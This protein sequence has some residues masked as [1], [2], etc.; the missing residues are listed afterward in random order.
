MVLL[1]LLLGA[2]YAF[3]LYYRNKQNPRSGM[4]GFNVV[5]SGLRF[6]SASLLA[7]LLLNPLLR[8]VRRDIQK[9]EILIA[10][11]NSRSMLMN[12]D[13]NEVRNEVQRIADELEAELG[14]DYRIVRAGFDE[15][16]HTE[17]QYL[18]DFD[19][20]RTNV[21]QVI[22]QKDR[23]MTGSGARAVVLLS[24][25]IY[26]TGSYPA[27]AAAQSRI[28]I[29]TI[30]FGD[31][32]VYR[33]VRIAAVRINSL[34]FLGNEFPIEVDVAADRAG[35]GQSS[36]SVYKGGERLFTENITID[37]SRYTRTFRFMV[38]AD[39]IGAASYQVQV[40]KLNGERNL[41]NNSAYIS[42]EVID[43][44]QKILVNA[45]APHP[46]IAALREALES[47]DQYE[48]RFAMADLKSLQASDYDMVITHQMPANAA[49][50]E[51]LKGLTER[52]IPFLAVLGNATRIELFNR[53]DVG[54]RIDGN[55]ANFNQ[56]VPVLNANFDLFETEQNVRDLL[57]KV[58]PL[59]A[60]FGDYTV[61]TRDFVLLYQQVGSVRTELPMLS[62]SR[63]ESYKFGV[64]FGEGIWRWRLFDYE[65]H[66]STDKFRAFFGKVSQFLAIKD[67][68]RK[69]RVTP[70]ANSLFENEAISFRAELYNDN[71]EPVNTSNVELRILNEAGKEFTYN[72]Q[73]V[74]KFYSL[75][76]GNFGAGTYRY[77]ASTVLAGR[78]EQLGGTFVV[79]PLILEELNLTANHDVL[80][81]IAKNSN[82]IY[83]EGRAIEPIIESLKQEEAATGIVYSSVSFRDVIDLKW[84][85]FLLFG[86]VALE[87]IARRWAGSY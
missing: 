57:A 36:V 50:L 30:P 32:T 77:T 15:A 20:L 80:R 23:L 29:H 40:G 81:Q 56:V 70:S 10:V 19:G 63:D 76:P 83:A 9:P 21:Q 61:E 45:H 37:R 60:P 11:D 42:T 31:T 78:K 87:W 27:Y 52:K 49:E 74:G 47:N 16:I 38:K 72:F 51:Y 46:D 48:V 6:L 34:A 39:K 41:R 7:I 28:P 69:F 17:E 85:F 8:S 62:F 65:Q 43:G 1:C 75:T 82:G 18:P 71:Y 79:K 68:K 64:L 3:G 86:L 25:G 24:D 54:T 14:S 26:N 13:S 59:S 5:L 2:A 33:D 55:R 22:D 44:R 67:D 84:L 58:P 66:G 12:A 53:L 4:R 35:G 73:P